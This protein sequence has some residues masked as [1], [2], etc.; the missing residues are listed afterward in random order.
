MSPQVLHRPRT[1]PAAEGRCAPAP[2]SAVD[3]LLRSDA[4]LRTARGADDAGERYV[5]AHLAALRAAA[6]VLAVRGRPRRGSTLNVWEV[7]PRVAPELTEWATFFAAGAPRR[8]AIEAG[9]AGAVSTRQA[10]DLVREAATFA[11]VV[12]D[13]LGVLPPAAHSA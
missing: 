3:L 5:A 4:G 11:D 6:A 2:A 13:L 9:L 10:D 8:A 1:S 7:L 12:A